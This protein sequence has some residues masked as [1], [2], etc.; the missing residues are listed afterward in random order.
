[1]LTLDYVY[2]QKKFIKGIGFG[3]AG[4]GVAADGFAGEGR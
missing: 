1:M 3:R 4:I 2:I